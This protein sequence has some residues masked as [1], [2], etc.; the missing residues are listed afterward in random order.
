MSVYLLMF[1]NCSGCAKQEPD[2][3][4]VLLRERKNILPCI[5]RTLLLQA[6]WSN[7]TLKVVSLTGKTMGKKNLFPSLAHSDL[8][9]K[10]VKF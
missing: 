9:D 7:I 10:S 4:P 5:W 6:T 2:N 8:S 3:V 1:R